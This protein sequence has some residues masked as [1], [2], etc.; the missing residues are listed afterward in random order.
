MLD[1]Y[2]YIH[3]YIDRFI[4]LP[5]PMVLDSTCQGQNWGAH[6]PMTLKLSAGAPVLSVFCASESTSKMYFQKDFVSS[7]D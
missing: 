3:I 4:A 5:T 7:T 6:H 1:I 2:I